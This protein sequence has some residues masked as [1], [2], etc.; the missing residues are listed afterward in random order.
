MIIPIGHESFTVR[1]LPWVT[2]VIMGICVFA[3]IVTNNAV[4]A[5]RKK[6]FELSQELS[7]YYLAH[8][9]LE[10]DE[11]LQNQLFHGIDIRDFIDFS[12][13]AIVKPDPITLQEEQT[14]LNRIAQELLDVLEEKIKT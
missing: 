2:F 7:E 10:L 5:N 13:F 6:A 8:P 12:D 9:Y 3:Y 14:E 1:R 11:E 4:T